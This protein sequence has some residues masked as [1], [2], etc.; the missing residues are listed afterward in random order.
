MN[1][2]IMFTFC[3]CALVHYLQAGWLNLPEQSQVLFNF[4]NWVHHTDSLFEHSIVT[5][6]KLEFSYA[7][8]ILGAAML[9]LLPSW[10]T[11]IKQGQI[12]RK[13]NMFC[14]I[15]SL[16]MF[17]HKVLCPS[18]HWTWLLHAVVRMQHE[19]WLPQVPQLCVLEFL[20]QTTVC[21]LS[22]S[23]DMAT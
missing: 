6:A 21:H 12:W 17:W 16:E 4:K 22:R 13:Q 11:I 5:F 9:H 1:G 19:I 15:R 18:L 7:A 20:T 8:H 10:C 23:Y 2:T 3:K 14:M